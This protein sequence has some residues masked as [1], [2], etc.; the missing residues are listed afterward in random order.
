MMHNFTV[1]F[2]NSFGRERLVATVANA[3]RDTAHQEAWDAIMKFLDGYHYKT[4]YQRITSMKR[5]GIDNVECVDVGSY[6][7]FFYIYPVDSESINLEE[8][9]DAW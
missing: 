1:T 2:R 9:L 6:T 7:E 5:R 8:K 4:Y 3:D